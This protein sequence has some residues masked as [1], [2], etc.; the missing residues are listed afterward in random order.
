MIRPECL[1]GNSRS[2]CAAVQPASQVSFAVSC[3]TTG[4]CRC[5]ESSPRMDRWLRRRAPNRRRPCPRT[6]RGA[7][8]RWWAS[9]T[10][11]RPTGPSASAPFEFLPTCLR[12]FGDGVGFPDLAAGRGVERDHTAAEGAARIGGAD[13][14][15]FLAGSDRHVHAILE[16]PRRAGD[17]GA[18]VG[19]VTCTFQMRFPGG[20]IHRVDIGVEVAE[21]RGSCGTNALHHNRRAHSRVGF[22][23]PVQASGYRVERIDQAGID[24]NENTRRATTEGWPITDFTPGNPKAHLSFKLGTLA[25]GNPA[26]AAD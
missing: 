12:H 26:D 3:T 15:A 18:W 2:F 19:I 25:A 4:S 7:W 24:A 16:D 10:H 14:A 8:D 6:A 13:S 1:W 5:R 11:P 9:S 20:R 21:V 17:A 23:G 22:E